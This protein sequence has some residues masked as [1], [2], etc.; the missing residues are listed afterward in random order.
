MH[1]YVKNVFLKR[2][3][4]ETR[5]KH[6]KRRPNASFFVSNNFAGRVL[7]PVRNKILL[8][9]KLDQ[10]SVDTQKIHSLHQV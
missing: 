8:L 2:I 10:S 4:Y 6:K 9:D 1:K 3:I 5:I 7:K